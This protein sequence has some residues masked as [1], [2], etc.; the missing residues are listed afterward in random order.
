MNAEAVAK[1]MLN[2]ASVA[3][4][5]AALSDCGRISISWIGPMSAV[6]HSI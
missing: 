6:M 3:F 4:R 5:G 2:L 1:G